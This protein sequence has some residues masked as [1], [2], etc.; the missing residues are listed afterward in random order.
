MAAKSAPVPSERY[1][2]L[3]AAIRRE[4]VAMGGHGWLTIEITVA[5]SEPFEMRVCERN[6]RYR[7]TAPPPP[8]LTANGA[9]ATLG[10]TE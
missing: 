5:D 1:R 2:N 3:C 7:L 4:A 10:A 6:A 8:A 9:A